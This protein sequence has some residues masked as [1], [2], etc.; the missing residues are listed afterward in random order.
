MYITLFEKA[1]GIQNLSEFVN[2]SKTRKNTVAVVTVFLSHKHNETEELN[3][4]IALLKMF[5]SKIANL[6]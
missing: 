4:A 1:Q 6:L 3:D 2:E 5:S